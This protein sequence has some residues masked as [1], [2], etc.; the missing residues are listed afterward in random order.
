MGE[1]GALV[2]VNALVLLHLVSWGTGAS[3]AFWRVQ[4]EMLGTTFGDFCMS[5]GEARFG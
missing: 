4:A 2:Y 5:T 1:V 3:G